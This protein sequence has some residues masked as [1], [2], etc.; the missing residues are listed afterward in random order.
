MGTSLLGVFHCNRLV[1]IT[2]KKTPKYENTVMAQMSAIR[3]DLEAKNVPKVTPL[4]FPRV[5]IFD[6]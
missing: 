2:R 4:D 1:I 3:S 6:L 5:D